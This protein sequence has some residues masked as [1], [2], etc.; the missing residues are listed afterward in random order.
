M[1]ASLGSGRTHSTGEALGIRR[2]ASK[3]SLPI[4]SS[5]RNNQEE[6]VEGALRRL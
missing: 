2:S 5:L 1:N 6:I 3:H 4:Q